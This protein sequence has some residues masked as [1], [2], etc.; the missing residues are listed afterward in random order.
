MN[1]TGEVIY[2]STSKKWEVLQEMHN[3]SYIP[4]HDDC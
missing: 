4:Y 2:V 3:E 1:L